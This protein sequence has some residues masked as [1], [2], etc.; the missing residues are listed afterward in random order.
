MVRLQIDMCMPMASGYGLP[1]ITKQ[2]DQYCSTNIPIQHTEK[3]LRV[4]F[5]AMAVHYMAVY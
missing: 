3:G 2:L 1:H 4:A 5:P